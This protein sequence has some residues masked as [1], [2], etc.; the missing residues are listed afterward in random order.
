[1]NRTRTAALVLAA[2]AAAL[3]P[4]LAATAADGTAYLQDPSGGEKAMKSMWTKDDMHKVEAQF[5]FIPS[6]QYKTV[7][8]R[9]PKGAEEY[10]RKAPDPKTLAWEPAYEFAWSVAD[11]QGV[12]KVLTTK[13]GKQVLVLHAV[14]RDARRAEVAQVH[15]ELKNRPATGRT[16]VPGGKRVACDTGT[17]TVEWS[18]TRTGYGTLKGSLP[19]D[20]SC[21]QYRTAFTP[22]NQGAS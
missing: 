15:Q 14:L 17:Y 2:V 11:S 10:E 9:G 22:R 18:V 3:A 12:K 5:R 1:M 20:S 7:M 13:D 6:I 8:R 21:E 19:W 16:K 4:A